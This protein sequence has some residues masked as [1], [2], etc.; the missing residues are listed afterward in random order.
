MN[1]IDRDPEQVGFVYFIQIQKRIKRGYMYKWVNDK[2]KIGSSL[3]PLMRL[4]EHMIRRNPVGSCQIVGV[5]SVYDYLKC[6][7]EI[8]KMT[9]GK[10][11]IPHDDDF[12]EKVQKIVKKYGAQSLDVPTVETLLYTKNIINFFS[13]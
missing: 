3:N 11:E 5:W 8:K 4:G 9:G 2:I 10:E 6:E 13:R 7:A 12:F 1:D